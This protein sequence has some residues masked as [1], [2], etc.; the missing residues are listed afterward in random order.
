MKDLRT[1][2][3]AVLL[4]A[5]A[6]LCIAVPV[7][8]LPLA[9][10]AAVAAGG[11]LA[12]RWSGRRVN[13]LIVFA[14]LCCSA[15]G[16]VV[17]GAQPER[18]ALARSDGRAVE[19]T[20]QVSSSASIGSD[21]RLW[22]DAQTIA[23]GPPGRAHT[24]SA[25]V[26]V[27]VDPVDGVEPGARL[28]ILGQAKATGPA[29]R[30][31]L[32]VFGRDV[33]VVRPA[34]GIFAIAAGTRA[35]FIARA[36]RLPE[37]GA[38]LLP[39]LAVG[40]TRAVSDELNA[41]MLASGL[42]HLTAVSGANCMIIV[43]VVFWLVSLAGGGRALRVVLS[44]LALGAF[45]VLVTP[46]PSV[47]RAAVMAALAML[48]ILLGRPSAGLAMLALAV[49]GLLIADPWFAA[50]PGFALSAAAT[51]ALLV[52]SRPLL[53]GLG[54]WMP[55]P[56]A[57]ALSVPLAAQVVCGPII[58]LFSEQQSLVSIPANLIAEPAAPI[59]TVIGLLACLTA[60]VAPLA[61]LFAAAA[62]LP[63]AWIHVTATVSAGLPGA[64]V[65]VVPGGV[66]ALVVGLLSAAAVIVLV[67]P[68][69]GRLRATSAVV[70]V[71]AVAVGGGRMLLTGP[72]APLTTPAEWAIAACDIGQGDAVLLR[73]AGRTALVDTGPDP[74]ALSDCLAQTGT[75][76][77]DL[78]VL[79]HFDLDHVGGTSAV[80]GMVGTVLHGPVVEADERRMLAELASS[81]ATLRD[82]SA[83]MSGT[84]GDARWRV[85]WP[86]PDPVVFPSGN[87]AS[88]VIEVAGGGVPRTLLLGDLGAGSQRLLL[89]SGR[90]RGAFDVVKVAHHGSRDQEPALYEA[91]DAA[92]GVISVGEDND[93]GHPRTETLS[94]LQAVGTRVLR[95]DLRG[96]ILL[97]LHGDELR[98]WSTRAPPPDSS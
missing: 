96:L 21:G 64:T 76:R 91:I 46:E 56:L 73:S 34:S 14:L 35:A 95:T 42:S 26:R 16:L 45:V 22:F 48:S 54:R 57:L 79:T 10:A 84:L 82:A 19:A 68:A 11:L 83:G 86:N 5:V 13:G 38:G 2:A 25:P 71:V 93:Y 78:L 6:L 77:I 8:A 29:E 43:A 74:D 85:V 92:A 40:D 89:S 67:R 94:L 32:V 65:A 18:A 23:L 7:V 90:V 3:L 97:G 27:G 55:A 1:S 69:S 66:A 31:G 53:R 36:T 98:V 24:L 72:L 49:C 63:A 61:D 88:V 20:V 39:G 9:G 70:L 50:S 15:V 44:L 41:A 33:E 75:K 58:A 17:A 30:A 59:A 51:A 47:V 87:D 12:G 81:G 80:R 28:H 60:G 37:P 52:L 62:W 4:W